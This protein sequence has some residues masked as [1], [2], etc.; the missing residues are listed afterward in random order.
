MRDKKGNKTDKIGDSKST[1]FQCWTEHYELLQ[2][3]NKKDEFSAMFACES[4]KLSWQ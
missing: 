2:K 1:I 4:V 3:A